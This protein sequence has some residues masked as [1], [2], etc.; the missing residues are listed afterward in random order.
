[1]KSK[2]KGVS[3]ESHSNKVALYNIISD[4]WQQTLRKSNIIILLKYLLVAELGHIVAI[5]ITCQT[6]T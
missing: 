1:M 6:Q 3:K 5:G 2:A 4:P